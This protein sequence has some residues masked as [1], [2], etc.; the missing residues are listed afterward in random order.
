MSDD[1]VSRLRNADLNSPQA[2]FGSRIFGEA[3]DEIERLR[4]HY[5]E[6]DQII[7]DLMQDDNWRTPRGDI[8]PRMIRYL[9]ER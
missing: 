3:A 8:Y 1:L 9:E 2:C 4:K 6:A 7:R 5:D